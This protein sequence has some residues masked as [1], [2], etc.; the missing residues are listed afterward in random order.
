LAK[1]SLII[2]DLDESYARR[3]SGYINSYHGAAFLVSCFTRADSFTGYMEQQS[4]V[5]VLLISPEFY[6]I[7]IGYTNVKLKAVLSAGALSHEYSGFQVISK[8][9]TGEKLLSEVVHLFS[10]L[11]PS[12]LRF[13]SYLKNAELIGVYSPAGGT[14]KTTIA[15]ALAMECTELG[16]GS[17]YLNLESIQSTGVFFSMNSKRNLSYIFYYLKEKTQNLS[18]RMDGIKS[19]EE[20]DGVQYFNPPESPVEYEE[21]NNEE[22]E[23]LIQGIKGMGCYDFVFI[24]MSNTFD[25]KNYKIMGLCDRIVLVTLQEPIS[26]YKSK[27]MFNEL[28]K[29]SD[30]DKECVSDKFVTVINKYKDKG[31]ES[32]ESSAGGFPAAVRIPEYTRSL[33]KEDGRLAIDDEGFRQGI[34][35]LF[36]VISGK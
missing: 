20:D 16:M 28:V 6:D 23:Q 36:K 34:N 3:L 4:E 18:F 25:M 26:L 31:G 15:A 17:F 10:R 8:Y 13:S 22:L 9:N 5:D 7:S 29:L 2:A 24:D 27:I 30:T 11:N 32:I 14:G 33:I 12:E 19:S 1:L 21:I 35:Q